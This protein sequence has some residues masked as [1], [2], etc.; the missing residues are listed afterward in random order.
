M[1]E[2]EKTYTINPNNN[3]W[4]ISTPNDVT[5][6]YLPR[7]GA[8]N[9]NKP[10]KG[11]QMFNLPHA[12]RFSA[13]YMRMTPVKGFDRQFLKLGARLQADFFIELEVRHPPDATYSTTLDCY[14]QHTHLMVQGNYKQYQAQ[15]AY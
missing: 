7:R 13:I 9:Y 10:S 2:I 4:F 3:H 11:V 1:Q 14:Q 8:M 5:P 6:T 12:D 15:H